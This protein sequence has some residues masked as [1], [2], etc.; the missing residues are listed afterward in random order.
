MSAVVASALAAFPP[1]EWT[2]HGTFENFFLSGR[3]R[4]FDL[5]TDPAG[6][7]FVSGY[8]A[9]SASVGGVTL[10]SVGEA[11]VL[12]A[13]YTTTG[14]FVW[15]R[16]AGGAWDDEATA[17][18][19]DWQGNVFV[20]GVFH[21]TASF[22]ATQLVSAGH[23]DMFL[24]KYDGAGNLL[25][26]RRG[27]GSADD[28]GSDVAV[29]PWGNCYVAGRFEFTAVFGADTLV[30]TGTSDSDL[31]LVKYDPS[32][33]VTWVIQ[34]SS[35]NWSSGIGVATDPS[36]NVFLG[37][38]SSGNLT[39]GDSTLAQSGTLVAKLDSSGAVQWI[40]QGVSG[41]DPNDIESDGQGSCYLAGRHRGIDFGDTAFVQNSMYFEGYLVKWN[42]NGVY[43]WGQ[44]FSTL[45]LVSEVE[46]HNVAVNSLDHV[47]VTAHHIGIVEFGDT[48]GY[49]EGSGFMV[50]YDASGSYQDL[51]LH[52][53]GSET[54]LSPI[55]VDDF[56]N[57]YYISFGDSIIVTNRWAFFLSKWG[58]N[59]PTAVDDS[60]TPSTRS[61]LYPNYPNPFN[62]STTIRYFVA[63]AGPVDVSVYDVSGALVRTLVRSTSTRGEHDTAWDGRDHLGRAVASGVY[64]YRLRTG[65]TVAT[66]KMVL[67]K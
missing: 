28:P 32:G 61:A 51:L 6:N 41:F 1:H 59:P 15:A 30:S 58:D 27:G 45:D 19:T 36:G 57:L 52:G 47:F 25:W 34:G 31:F 9:D 48:L 46:C 40:R 3:Y 42:S 11:D 29:D 39:L 13:K 23:E 38:I 26:V 64:F 5:A 22:D 53:G 44:E 16:Q 17:V 20:T 37:G 14:A 49:N 50:E 2:R 62:P 8:F 56:D 7:V 55:A 10:T 4:S 18:A 35:S 24:A 12:L 54:W 67:L 33:N 43:Q 65:G 60:Q 66:R 21:D 63:E